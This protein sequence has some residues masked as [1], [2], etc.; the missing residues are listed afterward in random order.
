MKYFIATLLIGFIAISFIGSK[1]E[2]VYVPVQPAEIKI[3]R[4]NLFMGGMY[5]QPSYSWPSGK[6]EGQ[7]LVCVKCFN[8]R[9]Q[10]LDYGQPGCGQTLTG[11]MLGIDSCLPVNGG[12][13]TI[14]TGGSVR[15]K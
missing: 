4:P 13:L 3:E 6:Q 8:Q 1:C 2:H 10:V 12:F 14:D 7:D 9:K 15:S 5:Y 11:L